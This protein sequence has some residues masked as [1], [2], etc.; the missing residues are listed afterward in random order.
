MNIFPVWECLSPGYKTHRSV[1]LSDIKKQ[2]IKAKK[3]N[4]VS[5]GRTR[6]IGNVDSTELQFR[7]DSDLYFCLPKINYGNSMTS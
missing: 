7:F 6:K 4:E 5:P 2:S 3:P 1:P